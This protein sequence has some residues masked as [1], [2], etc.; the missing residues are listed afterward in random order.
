[1]AEG[2]KDPKS[3]A[4]LTYYIFEGV[5]AGV[6]GGRVFHIFARSGGGGGSTKHDADFDGG[7][8]L[9]LTGMKTSG[10][11]AKHRH[12]GPIPVGRYTIHKPAKHP[13]LGRAAF[14]EPDTRTPMMGRDGFFIHGRGP[15]GSDGCI[16][17]S[18]EFTELLDALE[19]DG[20]GILHVYAA[21]GARR[22]EDAEMMLFGGR[23]G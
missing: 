13:H 12:G 19:K 15:H 14:L 4:S 23:I 10:K 7:Y 1:M 9:L 20:G 2:E 22:V 16:V 3:G 17:P 11:G 6:A 18:A 21:G 5:L 8:Y